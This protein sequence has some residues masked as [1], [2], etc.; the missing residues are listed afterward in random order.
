[1]ARAF[2]SFSPQFF[3]LNE[4]SRSFAALGSY[5]QQDS[6]Y[7]PARSSLDSSGGYP[8]YAAGGGTDYAAAGAGAGGAAGGAGFGDGGSFGRGGGNVSRGFH[9]YG[10]W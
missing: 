2:H 5:Q 4:M 9:P 10:R 3:Q 8:A 6:Q 7:G 1:M